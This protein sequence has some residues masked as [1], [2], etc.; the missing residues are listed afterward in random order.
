[1]SEVLMQAPPQS[2]LQVE[3]T[4]DLNARQ[5]GLEPGFMVRR[6]SGEMEQGWEVESISTIPEGELYAGEQAAVIIKE[7]TGPDGNPQILEKTVRA[8]DL[9]SWQE[10]VETDRNQ[11]SSKMGSIALSS[12]VEIVPFSGT[13]NNLDKAKAAFNASKESDNYAHLLGGNELDDILDKMSPAERKQFESWQVE[14][15]ANRPKKLTE[16]LDEAEKRGNNVPFIAK[17]NIEELKNTLEATGVSDVFA[18]EPTE[19]DI[20]EGISHARDLVS[21]GLAGSELAGEPFMDNAEFQNLVNNA[22]S[23]QQI[24][25]ETPMYVK[26]GSINGAEGFDSWEGRG[27]HGRDEV[28]NRESNSSAA[29][30]SSFEQ[31]VDYATRGTQIKK[32]T[33]GELN[34]FITK[35]GVVKTYTIGSHRAAAAKLRGEP[36]GYTAITIYRV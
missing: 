14:N 3:K 6:T 11:S 26:P 17:E 27:L 13:E 1:M 20:Q 34:I 30:R 22:L 15:A 19:V 9:L 16:I 12:D 25:L 8:H 4:A 5:L 7:T 10:S 36:L 21:R 28:A 23:K 18:A 31:I 2:E 33:D 29:T 35:D 32:N 24:W